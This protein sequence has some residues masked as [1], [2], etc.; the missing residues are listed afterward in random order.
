[1]NI[2]L[3]AIKQTL[4]RI[5]T[6]QYISPNEGKQGRH[7][8]PCDCSKHR[9]APS[10]QQGQTPITTSPF[11][12]PQQ[13]VAPVQPIAPVAPPVVEQPPVAQTPP[14]A[15]PVVTPPQV[16]PQTG[17]APPPAPNTGQ[18]VDADIPLKAGSNVVQAPLQL[19]DY[20][21]MTGQPAL[22]FFYVGRT[23]NGNGKYFIFKPR[24]RVAGRDAVLANSINIHMDLFG[25]V[26]PADGVKI[27]GM[28][29][30]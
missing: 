21:G 19:S 6:S 13:P 10:I 16:V 29:L 11:N 27:F 20:S 26:E 24:K 25:G 18:A 22:D 9:Q 8:L 4:E 12:I 15:P 7:K 30:V 23:G 28:S 17:F 14:V 5:I 3:S 1:M 2:S